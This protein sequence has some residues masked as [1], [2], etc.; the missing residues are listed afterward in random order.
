M[1]SVKVPL[2]RKSKKVYN[3]SFY[4]LDHRPPSIKITESQC[5]ENKNKWITPFWEKASPLA[6]V[7]RRFETPV[8]W[9]K[10]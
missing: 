7:F 10:Y 1:L 4:W 5:A 9:A 6:N 8:T 3:I 2:M